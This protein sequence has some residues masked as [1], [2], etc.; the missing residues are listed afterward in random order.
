MATK[1]NNNSK[2]TVKYWNIFEAMSILASVYYNHSTSDTPNTDYRS[3]PNYSF[4]TDL[5]VYYNDTDKMDKYIKQ[6]LNTYCVHDFMSYME[7]L[8]TISFTAYLVNLALY[9]EQKEDSL[10]Q[11]IKDDDKLLATLEKWYNKMMYN[12][13]FYKKYCTDDEIKKVCEW[14]NVRTQSYLIDNFKKQL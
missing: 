10:F 8:D 7:L 5:Y 13:S 9:T 6:I 3:E 14:L 2:N 11:I 12:K 4:M 1:T